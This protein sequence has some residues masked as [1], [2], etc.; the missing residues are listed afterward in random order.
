MN[1]ALLQMTSVDDVE[2]NLKQILTLLEQ[3]PKNEKTDL[4]LLP[5][6]CLF[7][8]LKEGEKIQGFD[9]TE[10]VFATLAKKAKENNFA[11]H[12]GS[13]P[14][15]MDGALFN[16]AVM[17]QADGSFKA[18][19]QKVHLFDIDLEGQKSV[20][21]SDVFRHGQGPSSFDL[22]TWHVGETICYDLRF[23]ELFSRYAKLGADVIVV[24]SAFLV[25][26][27][28]AHWEILLR[29]RAIESQCYILAPAQAG[30]HQS[31]RGERYTYGHS[32]IVDPWGQILQQGSSD[33]PE[34][35]WGRLEKAKIESVRRQ[36]PMKGHRRL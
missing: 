19:Y 27:G 32:L 3:L 36:I 30:H 35:L 28:K 4:I 31:A 25:T 13:L 21:E 9:L 18:T 10:P 22:N 12:L 7:M 14:L 11:I 6:N 16:S 2:V 1:V 24:P 29:A 17:I 20:R 23:S 8:R 15:R 33:K 26:T 5:E 34:V